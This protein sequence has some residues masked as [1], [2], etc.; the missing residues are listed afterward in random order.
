SSFLAP[1]PLAAADPPAELAGVLHGWGLRTLGDF[2][3]LPRDE[4]VR[5][6]G[7]EGLALWARAAGGHPRPLHPVVPPRQFFAAMELEHEIETLEPLL[8]ILRRFLERLTLELH[9]SQFVAVELTL[10]L[11]LED[12]TTH[13]RSFRLPE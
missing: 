13:T 11:R 9:A 6:F 4:I 12:E 8:F 5:R 7:S 2:T 3:A 10:T 1:L